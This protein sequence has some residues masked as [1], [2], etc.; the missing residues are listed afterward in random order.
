MHRPLGYRGQIE[1]KCCRFEV[2]RFWNPRM[3][4][5]TAAGIRLDLTLCLEEERV[6]RSWVRWW[7]F[8]GSMGMVN[9]GL[10]R[11]RWRKLNV[12]WGSRMVHHQTLLSMDETASSWLRHSVGSQ[13]LGVLYGSTGGCTLG[14]D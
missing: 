1:R 10:W 5:G 12:G 4:G 13:R 3:V 11:W 2:C 6:M 9:S 7:L 8:R 14:V